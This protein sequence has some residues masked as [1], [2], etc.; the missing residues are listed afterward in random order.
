MNQSEPA[1]NDTA[2][3]K[4]G[5]DFMRVSIGGDIKVFG[6]FSEKEIPNASADEIS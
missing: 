2:V 1:A 5:I 6:N 3:L 4:E